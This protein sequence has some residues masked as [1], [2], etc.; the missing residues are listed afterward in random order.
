MFQWGA[1][2]NMWTVFFQL[3]KDGNEVTVFVA[4]FKWTHKG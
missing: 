3:R 4:E 1:S 2:P